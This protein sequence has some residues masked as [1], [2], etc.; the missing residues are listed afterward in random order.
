M[1]R[2]I[3]GQLNLISND[4]VREGLRYKKE[5]PYYF[6]NLQTDSSKFGSLSSRDIEIL[7]KN[8]NTA[9]NWDKVLV[10]ADFDPTLVR[11]CAFWGMVRLGSLTA[12]FLEYNQLR[13]PVGLNNCTIISC[14]IGDNVVL[15]NVQFL[16]HYIIGDECI[17]FNIDEMITTD[18]ARFGN[19]IV[20]EG[21]EENIR[22]WLEIGNENGGRKIL[23]FIGIWPADAYLWSK[24]R[25]DG[26]LM[27]RFV[28]M[29]DQ[30]GDK[31]R[32][33]YGVVGRHSVIKNSRIIKNTNIGSNCYIKGTNKLKNLTILSTEEEPTQIGEGC[34]LVNGIIGLGNN[35]FYGVKAVRF[36][37]GSNVQLKYGARLLNSVLGS[38]SN[39]S[40]CEVLNN[41]IFPFHEQHH[42]NSFLIASTVMGQSNIA[43]GAT[44]GSNHNSRAAD[45]EI[46]AKRGFWPGLLSN[47]KHN[48]YFASFCL[49]AKGNYHHELNITL[50]FALVAEG[51]NPSMIRIFP[52]FWFR[53][54]MYALIRNAWKFK[55][56]D[57]RKTREQMVETDFL[58]PDTIEEMFQGIAILHEAIQHTLNKQITI[59]EIVQDESLDNRLELK[60]DH[61]INKGKA[62]VHKPVQAIRLYQMM[63]FHYGALELIKWL[64]ENKDITDYSQI[65]SEYAPP[66]RTWHNIG[67]QL[68]SD[69]DLKKLLDDVKSESIDSWNILHRRY[70]DLWQDYPRQRRNHAIFSLLQV[71]QLNINQLTPE[72]IREIL[73]REKEIIQKIEAWTFESREKDYSNA[74]RKITFRNDKEMDAVLGKISDNSFLNEFKKEN[75]YLCAEIDRLISRL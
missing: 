30:L 36:V 74:F 60:L 75:Y 38:N 15:R 16:S 70:Y 64:L 61:I 28:Q 26:Q 68:I 13:L 73:N 17:L 8:N 48:S 41:L 19:G 20:K 46:V 29:T 4:F 1:S 43:A 49:I 53:H 63:I 45:G 5:D 58:A 59:E 55:S 2:I 42:N 34:E 21:E 39:I 57:K 12:S 47:F 67:G 27:Q 54:N 72:T 32:G 31:R 10:S 22:I 62:I 40:C 44:I 51:D 37:T 52:G 56:R 11:N 24:Y 65:F 35:I 3:K 69:S 71:Q 9:E 6:R 14:D 33:Y 50:P 23:P 7:V 66:D 25:E 18:N